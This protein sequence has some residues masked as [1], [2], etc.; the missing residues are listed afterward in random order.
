MSALNPLLGFAAGALTILSPCVF[1]LVP[2]VLASAAQR[3][4]QGP[5]ALATGLVI[6]FTASGMALALLGSA[7]DFDGEGLRLGGAI[8]LALAGLALLFSPVQRLLA[9]WTTPLANWAG[10]RQDRLAGKGL[11]GQFAI[12]ALLGI[13]WSPCVGP[14]LGAATALAAQGRDVAEVAVVM[15]AFGCGIASVLL[16]IAFAGRGLLSRWRGRL[17]SAGSSGKRILSASLL[18]VGLFIAT[19]LDRQVEGR[20]V[21]AS[22]DWLIDAT[23]SI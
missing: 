3:H 22:P 17:M 12:G 8:I 1:P 2:L 5:L 11:F 20:L 15:L 14:T 9:R 13:V 16:V 7:L 4:R 23:T 19:G 18:A 21:A 10:T 6:A